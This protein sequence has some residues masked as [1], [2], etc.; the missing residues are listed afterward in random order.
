MEEFFGA[1]LFFA[2]LALLVVTIGRVIV[3][4]REISRQ[5]AVV[6]RLVETVGAGAD[7]ASVLESPTVRAF[8][9]RAVDRRTVVLGRVIRSVQ[10]GVVL[11]VIGV[12]FFFFGL[13]GGEEGSGLAALGTVC[14]ALAV[15]FFLAA[16][17]S[18][19][20]SKRW[21]LIDDAPSAHPSA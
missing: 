14:V 19:T 6:M 3:R 17:T 10:I 4:W 12:T 8:L 5:S 9:S 1:A 2:V 15:A 16:A 11:T 18:Y 7:A 13:A 21:G 20:L